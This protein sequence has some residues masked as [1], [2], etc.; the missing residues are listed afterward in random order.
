MKFKQNEI[1]F[2]EFKVVPFEHLE[3]MQKQKK[4]FL[5]VFIPDSF[6]VV[7]WAN[8]EI[9]RK[10]PTIS[11]M[12]PVALNGKPV[13]GNERQYLLSGDDQKFIPPSFN[14]EG[15][16]FDEYLFAKLKKNLDQLE[17]GYY[18]F[19]LS[20]LVIDDHGSIGYY[21]HPAIELYMGPDEK[22]PI[23]SEDVKK[24]I[25]QQLVD[26]LNEPLR[27]KPAF[28]EGKS[29]NARLTLGNYQIIVKDHKAV[30]ADRGGC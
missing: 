3:A 12:M 27:F 14:N 10:E 28:K 29:V 9:L 15:K 30:L 4:M 24:G 1:E 11:D 18:I 21:E 5:N 26:V 17:N 19:S 16:N 13:Y 6:P 25:E 22:K 7:N 8:G 23:I 2:G 20:R